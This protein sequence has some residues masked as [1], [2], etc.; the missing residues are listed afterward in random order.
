MPDIEPVMTA[1]RGVDAMLP[2][3]CENWRKANDGWKPPDQEHPLSAVDFWE[4]D[5]QG[6]RGVNKNYAAVDAPNRVFV[7]A[8]N[9]VKAD[10][11]G[12]VGGTFTATWPC[13]VKAYDTRTAER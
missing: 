2:S 8:P 4:G 12:D 7:T 11:D 3:G 6:G 13:R 5:R 1:V 9:G 10:R